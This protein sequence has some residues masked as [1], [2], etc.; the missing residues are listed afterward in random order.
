MKLS[1]FSARD[2]YPSAIWEVD[3][4]PGLI[5]YRQEANSYWQV[6]FMGFH[7]PDT[8]SARRLCDIPG[9]GDARFQ[10]RTQAL[11]AIQVALILQSA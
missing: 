6:G 10:T 3:D 1:K 8:E 4:Y 2:E 11:Q 7:S 9:V 5:V